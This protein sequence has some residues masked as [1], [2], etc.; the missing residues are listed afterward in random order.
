MKPLRVHIQYIGIDQ[1]G[2][3]DLG[4]LNQRITSKILR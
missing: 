1:N 4:R 3:L 2:G